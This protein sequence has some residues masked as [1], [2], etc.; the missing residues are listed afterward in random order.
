MKAFLA[1][2]FGRAQTVESITAS[3]ATMAG[4]LR[5]LARKR[6]ALA[7][8]LHQVAQR[9]EAEA[10][11]HVAESRKAYIVADK[12]AD[13]ISPDGVEGGEPQGVGA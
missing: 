12:I 10:A 7:E 9:A 4:A 6:V 13:L 2:L 1:R 11:E 5:T 3:M 8:T